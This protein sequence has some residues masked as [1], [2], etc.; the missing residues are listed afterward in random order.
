MLFYV[1]P[2]HIFLSY[3]L[4]ADIPPHAFLSQAY[5]RLQI[6]SDFQWKEQ[7]RTKILTWGH[8]PRTSTIKNILYVC[9]NF[10]KSGLGG[11]DTEF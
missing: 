3:T 8:Y 5:E 2:H 7:H 6:C 9:K 10:I 11:S 1:P 4:H